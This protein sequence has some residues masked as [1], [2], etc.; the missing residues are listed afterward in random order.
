M[1]SSPLAGLLSNHRASSFRE[2][3]TVSSWILSIPGTQRPAVLLPVLLI[4]ESTS[5]AACAVIH[6]ESGYG[7]LWTGIPIGFPPFLKGRK[8]SKQKRSVGIRCLS[9]PVLALWLPAGILLLYLLTGRLYQKK[10]RIRYTRVPAS[11]IKATCFPLRIFQVWHLP[12][13]VR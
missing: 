9:M 8:P 3:L 5:F 10:S 2:P 11:L 13:G 7:F 12:A 4:T 6:K 1:T